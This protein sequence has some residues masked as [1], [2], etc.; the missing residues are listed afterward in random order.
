MLNTFF[1]RFL[2]FVI[3]YFGFNKT[4]NAQ[5]LQNSLEFSPELG[6]KF[7]PSNNNL[8]GEVFGGEI[9]YHQYIKS[10][11]N[12]WQKKLC[13]ISTDWVFRYN[14][15]KQLK[16]DQKSDQFDDSFALLYAIN[17]S[18]FKHKSLQLNFSP[19]FGFGYTAKTI[20]TNSNKIIGSQINLYS[21]ATLKAEM[22]LTS[23]TKFVTGLNFLHLSNAAMRVPN[24][25][26]N[27]AS[28]S[29]GVIK[30]LTGKSIKKV[31]QN[32][33]LKSDSL[34]R[35][36]EI[37]FGANI[38]RR[39][40]YKSTDGLFKTGL[41]LGYNYK[42]DA[43]LGMGLG[44]DAVYYHTVF[45]PEKQSETY[46]SNATSFKHWRIGAAIGPDLAMGKFVLSPKYGYYLYF[47]SLKPI[48]TYWTAGFKYHLKQSV[49]LQAKLY[50]HKAE[51]DFMGFGVLFNF[52]K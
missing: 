39:G 6:L 29:L 38:G 24:L 33:L 51:A 43:V 4:I 42:Q 9:I 1:Y 48:N 3:L 50:V 5:I 26:L 21:R 41:Y 27:Q 32:T 37:E 10:E 31:N 40:V 34:Y 46:Q 36:H 18:L 25:G 47:N 30:N 17:I 16:V 14:Y 8:S 44:F 12:V 19:A 2:F 11:A 15:F 13:I 52:S 28:L 7:F 23:T 49:A 20:Y 35:K 45:N 22:P